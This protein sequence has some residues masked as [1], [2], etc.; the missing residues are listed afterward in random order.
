MVGQKYV[1]KIVKLSQNIATAVSKFV[2][3]KMAQVVK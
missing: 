2:Q 3:I 1:A